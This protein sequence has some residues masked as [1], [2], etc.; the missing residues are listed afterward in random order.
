M[1]KIKILQK[2]L[3]ALGM[4]VLLGAGCAGNSGTAPAPTGV[5]TAQPTETAGGQETARP[6]ETDGEQES[7]SLSDSPRWEDSRGYRHYDNTKWYYDRKKKR[8]V[9]SGTGEMYN[10]PDAESAEESIAPS[11]IYPNHTPI[12]RAQ[13]NAKE[14]VVKP[15]ITSIGRAAFAYF[16]QVEKITLPD[17][18]EKIGEGVFFRCE[19]LKEINIPDRVKTIGNISFLWCKSLEKITIGKNLEEIGKG[20]FSDCLSLR[21]VE[22]SRKNKCFITKNGGLYHRK[23][24]TL[25]LHYAKTEQVTIEEGTERIA[26]SAIQWNEKVRRITIPDSVRT[27]GDGA[28]YHCSRLEKI[29]FSGKS[30]LKEFEQLWLGTI[31]GLGHHSC[32]DECNR[33][34][35]FIAPESLERMPSGALT[36]CESLER[37][38]LGK[39]YR[40]DVPNGGR[41]SSG[42]AFR[43]YIVSEDNKEF[44]SRDGVLYDKYMQTLYIYPDRK[45]GTE[46][47]VPQSVKY[48]HYIPVKKNMM[49]KLVVPNKDTVFRIPWAFPKNSRRL[50]IYGRKG[51]DIYRIAKKRN[52]KFVEL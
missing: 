30:Q 13:R 44:C 16:Q 22:V 17:T 26:D 3:P 28:M 14:I 25:C 18:L 47:T 39:N 23:Q 31:D 29:T 38:Y 4:A 1:K 2:I 50:V 5:G 7:V 52:L 20:V 45:D 10:P 9:I 6:E 21:K 41:T 32:F 12:R 36:L 51:S 8:L 27:I 35:E 24:K 43:E 42:S 48:V 46:F 40:W 11:E 49:R 19:S 33:L 34:R 15:G 37:V